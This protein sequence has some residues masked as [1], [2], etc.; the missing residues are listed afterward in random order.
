MGFRPEPPFKHGDPLKTGILVANLGTP[1]AATPAT[2]RRYLKEFL[3]DSRVVEIPKPIWWFILNGIILNVRPKKTAAKYK[4]VWMP[5]GS[6][7]LVHTQRQA[8]MLKGYLGQK[9]KSPLEVIVGMRYGNPSIQSA[10][11]QLKEKGCNKILVLPMYPHYASSTTGTLI[12]KLGDVFKKMRN[13]PAIRTIRHY[14][15]H[16]A[17][18][19]AIATNIEKHWATNGRGDMLMMSFHG[20]PKF[21]LEKGDPYHCECLKTARLIAERLGLSKDKYVVSFQSRF[22]KQEWLKPYTTAT[23]EAL[24]KQGVKSLDVVCPGFAA[25]CLETLEEIAEEGKH[26]FIAAGGKQYQYIPVA[27]ATDAFI[28]ALTEIALENLGGWVSTEFDA[29]AQKTELQKSAQRAKD[30]TAALAQG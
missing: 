12:D 22:G 16:P 2:V 10:V 29:D 23:L 27:N 13:V 8:Q 28:H 19:K 24:G 6:P 3:S 15:D 18:I 9:I 4:T 14:H 25:D 7:L 30:A 26:D 21:H 11:D 17:Y 20:L 5:E 1:D